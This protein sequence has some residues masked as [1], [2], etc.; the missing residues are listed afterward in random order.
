M[1]EPVYQRVA[2]T[3]EIAPGEMRCVELQGVEVLVCRLEE[4][5][6]AVDNICSHARARM[7]EGRLRGH[8]VLCPVHGAA[9]DVRAR[10]TMLCGCPTEPGGL[11]D[12]DAYTLRAL[13][14]DEGEVVGEWPLTFTGTTSEYATSVS[15]DSPGTYQLRILAADAAKGNFGMAKASV[16]V[17]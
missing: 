6:F 9:F 3:S 8:R 14:L 7:S 16:V 17:R 1:A 2:A 10:V 12:S 11:W 4:G 13:L 5:F 15:I